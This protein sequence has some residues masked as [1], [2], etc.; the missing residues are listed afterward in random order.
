MTKELFSK[1]YLKNN[2]F[3]NIL[4]LLKFIFSGKLILVISLYL[5][6]SLIATLGELFSAYLITSYIVFSLGQNLEISSLTNSILLNPKLIVFVVIAA[7][8]TRFISLFSL[9]RLTTHI[10][11]KLTYSAFK[12]YMQSSFEYRENYSFEELQTTFCNRSA[13][14]NG[15]VIYTILNILN[16]SFIFIIFITYL[17]YYQ[18]YLTLSII[19]SVVF[20]YL[21]SVL[22][23]KKKL[24]YHSKIMNIYQQN[25]VGLV[26]AT[27]KETRNLLINFEESKI[28]ARYKELDFKLRNSSS[29]IVFLGSLPKV[30]IECLF[31]LGLLFF[32]VFFINTG[33]ENLSESPK[34][35]ILFACFQ[36]IV[37]SIQGIYSNFLALKANLP[38]LNYF[39]DFVFYEKKYLSIF[40]KNDP[41]FK[42]RT[43]NPLI[44]STIISYSYINKKEIFYPEF[45]I[46][47]G[48]FILVKGISGK[49]KTTWIDLLLGLRE[50]KTG[51]I[52]RNFNISSNV[53][54]NATINKEDLIRMNNSY[55][56]KFSK[57]SLNKDLS[58]SKK[59]RKLLNICHID[60]ISPRSYK[61][62]LDLDTKGLSSGQYQ[63]M[64]LFLALCLNPKILILDE[65]LNA[66]EIELEHKIIRNIRTNFKKLC[67]IQI[68]HRPYEK[69]IYN[70]IYEL[71]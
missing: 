28:S 1:N 55:F 44:E 3:S 64:Q 42:K 58:G 6:F 26:E 29:Q 45:K 51:N 9:P 49:G 16:Y 53:Y 67:L 40:N 15:G 57:L 36:R 31:F 37:P 14:L 21:I 10:S 5:S 27:I 63:R 61:N 52:N 34:L 12:A 65:A 33:G 2:N 60:F 19:F 54:L 48:E 66:I 18:P 23:S 22:F 39:L 24:N 43:K 68:S 70:K 30:L 47:E 7:A 59:Y 46:H 8:I 71:R 35:I 13:Q 38:V 11:N 20:L 62:L 4:K 17:I 56:L 69:E 50:P 25:L 32:A 41:F